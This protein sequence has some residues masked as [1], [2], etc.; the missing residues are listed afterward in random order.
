VTRE[1]AESLS[2][3]RSVLADVLDRDGGWPEL[4]E[5][6]LVGLAV[7]EAYGGEG[8]GLPEVSVL[9]RET[10]ARA[11][12][13][14]A[15]ETLCCGVLTLAEHGT[16]EQRE[17]LRGVVAGERVLTPAVRELTPATYAD[18]RVTGRKVGVTYAAEASHVLVTARD[19][20]RPV[21]ALV[22]LSDPGVTL[23]ESGSSARI[24]T[25][26]V[27][28]DGAG[29]QLFEG[30]A[31]RTLTGLWT[32]GLCLTAAGVVAGARDL[33]AAYIKGRTQFG[34]SLAEF[35]AVAM[36]IA[37][38]YIASRTLDLAAENVAWRLDQG[39]DA[40]DDLAVA[41]YWTCTEGPP[42]LR[43]CH[44]LHGGMGVD[45]SYPLHR[46]FS[47]VTDITHL[48]DVRADAVP[49]E[50]P[51]TKNLELTS[52]QRRLKQGLRDYF[53]GLAGQ[54]VER[55]LARDRHGQSYQR[56]VR[57]L[58]R[59]GWMGVGWPKEYGG[60]GL[61]EVEQTI[62]ANEAQYADVH[63][64]AVTLQTVGPTLIRYGSEKQKDLFLRRIL[65]GDVHFAIGYSEPDAG[66]DLASLR[67]TARRDGDH[68]VVNGQ[69]LW[70]TGGHQADYVWLAVRTD[71]DAPKHRGISILIVD[72]SDPGYSHTPIITA[73]GS[74]H[75]NATYYNDV[76]VPV[77]MLVGEENQGWK[78]IT[79]QLNHERVMLGPAGRIEG[80]RDRVLDWSTKA[81]VA[82]RP[83]V[84]ELMGRTTAAFRVNELLNWEVARA[85][86]LGEI[87]VG[88]ASSSKVFAA[89]R[90]QGLLDELARVVHRYG[91]PSEEETGRLADYLDGQKKRNLVLTFGGGVQEVQRELIAM[92]G[93]GLPRVPR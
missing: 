87:S 26:T 56:V 7:P 72:T 93:L 25:H 28:L 90:V 68:Y 10:G 58:G 82:E 48:L 60:H 73:D 71:P 64:P 51:T 61:G 5:A 79:T 50:D 78:L 9:L 75:V 8:L 47:W 21:A 18:G 49:L 23:V 65:D 55:E 92:F 42:A 20:G 41:A 62:F 76:R 91:D 88:D 29:A 86:E 89:D 16:E 57:Q 36:Q 69:K 74:H 70:T 40:G 27:V 63:L 38:V 11:K 37:D 34:R 59:D 31:A 6:G 19:G 12:H 32:A 83:D 30:G 2:A 43:T 52:E 85:A 13:L 15:W 33:T 84:V 1:R 22:D 46:Y 66:T 35:Q 14:P 81:G 77:D 17:L 53:A 45:E 3:V 54:Y 80:L 24:T 67:T 4:A 39:L 44:H